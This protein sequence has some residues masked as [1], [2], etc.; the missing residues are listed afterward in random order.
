MRKFLFAPGVLDDL[1]QRLGFGAVIDA[2]KTPQSPMPVF[3]LRAAE[4]RQLAVYLLWQPSL[5]QP[6]LWQ[7]ALGQPESGQHEANK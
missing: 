5:R 7:P 3:P 4:R 6:M 1:A 2:L